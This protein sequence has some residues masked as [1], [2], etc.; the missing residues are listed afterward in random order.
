MIIGRSTADAL[1]VA[2]GDEVVFEGFRLPDPVRLTVSGLYEVDR[3]CSA[4]TGP[5]TDLLAGPT[6]LFSAVVDDPAFV[7]ER[8]LLSTRPDGLDMDVHLRAAARGLPPGRVR[9]GRRAEPGDAP[10]CARSASTCRPR[11]TRPGRAGPARPAPGRDRHHRRGDATGGAV[12]VRPVPGRAPHLRGAAARHRPAQ[13]ARR[14]GLAGVGPDRAAE[15]PADGGRVP[16]SA[17][18]WASWPPPR[19]PAISAGSA[20]TVD[21]D[22]AGHPAAVAGRAAVG[23]LG[24]LVAAVVAEWRALR[25]SVVGLLRR[26][27]AR[28]RGWR[29]EVFDLVVVLVAVVGVYQGHVEAVLGQRSVDA[30]PARARP[31]RPGGGAAGGPGAALAGRAVG[32]AALRAG[33][34]GVAL[35]AL[36]LARRPG[37]H[38]VFAVLAVAMSV[39]ATSLV[40][41]HAA[42]DAWTQRAAQVVGADRVLT[43]RAENS[44]TLLA[45]VRAVDPDGTFAMAAARTFG[46]TS[47]DRVLAL[48]TAR[49]AA[50]A[51]VPPVYGLGELRPAG[52][53]AAPTRTRPAHGDRRSDHCGH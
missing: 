32:G 41:W 2:V 52:R 33:R 5:S 34:A 31:G 46:P 35:A 7:S 45:A 1:G 25:S 3:S 27:P 16:C 36:H 29:A 51:D 23:R 30:G 26:V 18:G 21:T 12:L 28:H 20:G 9:P 19:W 13:A 39:L 24:A 8:T 43:V 11:S 42:T 37:T 44:A 10:T 50:V 14:R 15:R 6:G 40:F 4:R 47:E 38:R 22:P 48:D 49:L 53:A 17:G